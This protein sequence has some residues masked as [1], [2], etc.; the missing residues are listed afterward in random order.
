MYF[1]TPE[2]DT[3]DGK[4]GVYFLVSI[5]FFRIY[6]NMIG[7][8]RLVATIQ[9]NPRLPQRVSAVYI[10]FQISLT[11]ITFH[12]ASYDKLPNNPPGLQPFLLRGEDG[13]H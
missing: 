5:Q 6:R 7:L 8:R 10:T 4:N 3:N 2:I 11:N 13:E 12:H 1:G 9:V